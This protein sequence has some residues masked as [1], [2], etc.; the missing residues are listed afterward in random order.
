MHAQKRVPKHLVYNLSTTCGQIC[1]EN[2]EFLDMVS[3]TKKSEFDT[4]R[5]CFGH[6]LG[7]E[8]FSGIARISWMC[9]G[10]VESGDRR[11]DSGGS[12]QGVP[13][14]VAGHPLGH[15]PLQGVP[16]G[17][18]RHVVGHPGTRLDRPAGSSTGRIIIRPII[19]RPDRSGLIDRS[20]DRS[21]W[22]DR[23]PDRPS[24]IAPYHKKHAFEKLRVSTFILFKFSKKCEKK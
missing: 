19:I 18:P 12:G 7:N 11:V 8:V 10:F 22:I 23:P 21:G 3:R 24:Q 16:K 13:G 5:I 14:D 15:P 6:V 2:H 20:P 9:P 4:G 1:I 17:V